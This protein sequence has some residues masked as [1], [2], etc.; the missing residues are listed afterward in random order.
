MSFFAL[1]KHFLYSCTYLEYNSHANKNF[2][3]VP[4][5]SVRY[6]E[7]IRNTCLD[8]FFHVLIFERRC[9]KVADDD[10]EYEIT[11]LESQIIEYIREC[12][13]VYCCSPTQREIGCRID[14]CVSIV[15][16]HLKK[17]EN[18]GILKLKGVR[19]I[20]VITAPGDRK[21]RND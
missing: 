8:T 16:R 21:I 14:R 5:T 7:F 17:L 12:Q 9:V 19:R 2:Q 18:A 6:N 15:N 20:E 3:L 11:S 13:Q 4:E 10:K 1:L